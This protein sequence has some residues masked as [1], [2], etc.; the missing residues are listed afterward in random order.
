MPKKRHSHKKKAQQRRTS[1]GGGESRADTVTTKTKRR[2]SHPL[3][4]PDEVQT[5]VYDLL[6]RLRH[7]EDSTPLIST[8]KV[9]REL[10][11][12]APKRSANVVPL[13][14]SKKRAIVRLRLEGCSS[15]VELDRRSGNAELLKG[16][17]RALKTK[18]MPKYLCL[19]NSGCAFDLNTVQDDS[20]ICVAD[21]EPHWPGTDEANP[22]PSKVAIGSRLAWDNDDNQSGLVTTFEEDECA[23]E[24]RMAPIVREETAREDV[25]EDVE[26]ALRLGL[27]AHAMR[28]EILRTCRENDVTVIAGATGCGKSTQ[29]PQYILEDC[30]ER[31]EPVRIVVTQ[32]RRLAAIALAERVGKESRTGKRDVG[33]SVR[34]DSRNLATARLEFCTVGVLLQRLRANS[35]YLDAV[36]HV[37]VDE[38]HERD[39]LTDFLLVL[40]KKNPPKKIVVMSATLDARLFA[41]YFGGSSRAVGFVDIPGRLFPVRELYVEDVVELLFP[42]DAKKY[43]QL[44]ASSAAK[45]EENLPAETDAARGVVLSPEIRETLDCEL[46]A[47]VALRV[48]ATSKDANV[49]VFAPGV[50]EIV[51]ICRC[52][53][54]SD[55]QIVVLPLHAGLS[56]SQ[57]RRVFEKAQQGFAKIVVATNVAET[58]IT[59]EDVTD[60]VDTG[61]VRE[62]RYRG[63]VSKLS[64]VW[65]SKAAARQRAG[66]AG[67]VRPGTVWRLYSR[68]RFDEQ[69]ADFTAPE[70]L[71]TPLEELALRILRLGHQPASF[72][73]YALQPPPRE[74]V[75]NAIDTLSALGAVVLDED[76]EGD[77][78]EQQLSGSTA[79]RDADDDKDEGD[80]SSSSE[81]EE[82]CGG[83]DDE[84]F[85][86]ATYRA[87]FAPPIPWKLTP[88]GY[89]MSN[90]PVECRLAKLLI[91]GCLFGCA[92]TTL[93][94]AAALSASKDVFYAPPS[95][96][97]KAAAAA[98]RRFAVGSNSDL[99]ALV[100]AFDGWR[101]SQ[102][103]RAFCSENFLS[104]QALREVDQL[105]DY[106][107]N[108][109]VDA[110]WP[111]TAN[112]DSSLRYEL[113]L[114][115][116]LLCA[117]LYPHLAVLHPSE[118][119]LKLRDTSAWQCHP[120]SVNFA[121]LA[122]S[123]KRVFVVYSAK[124]HT[125]KAYLCDTSVVDPI[126]LLL[127][128]GGELRTS[129][130]GQKLLLDRWLSFRASGQ[131]AILAIKAL[132]REIDALLLRF[133]VFD[134][135]KKTDVSNSGDSKE[136]NTD[137]RL[138]AAVV[139]TVRQVLPLV[140][141]C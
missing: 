62:M 72:L 2:A 122:S 91:L 82:D 96:L 140:S 24:V 105:R 32:P 18:R 110:G 86:L 55:Q 52:L 63:G 46:V 35:S 120:K 78:N 31:G 90:L 83:E 81:E 22:P 138:G 11:R 77:P 109:L 123:R 125:S 74:A 57:Q 36:T 139:E 128:A 98:K 99:V 126:A 44:S 67:R 33:Y 53:K 23:E 56:S 64:E 9:L 38:A 19:A 103:R 47:R 117:G 7:I 134:K 137:D 135:K 27:P 17:R 130:D 13:P 40:L 94:I 65:I 124:L 133:I 79:A 89:H 112:P 20:I 114:V 34:L 115:R 92:D 54:R 118:K 116:G 108:R 121:D 70:M 88:L 10:Q 25:G 28:D 29:V 37:V 136:E 39:A 3:T 102:D 58:S 6:A 16:V 59:I 75:K 43:P 132:R 61:R 45:K 119:S 85:S 93:T 8:S 1:S 104:Y 69:L 97:R 4:F 5:I 127:F 84:L 60:V 41:E 113:S 106:L 100:S 42:Q 66:R 68:Q 71:R 30:D 76:D 141:S 73:E 48:V 80:A 95:Q 101:S 26:D 15:I 12:R 14:N 107:R 131:N 87:A 111:A 49:L 50:A 129:I 51:K 21:K